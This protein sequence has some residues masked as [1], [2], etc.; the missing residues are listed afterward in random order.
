MINYKKYIFNFLAPLSS[1]SL[2]SVSFPRIPVL[3]SFA[4]WGC[5]KLNILSQISSNSLWYILLATSFLFLLVFE[6]K[7][8]DNPVI[9]RTYPII[10]RDALDEIENRAG[11]VN[12]SPEM[13]GK[14]ADWSALQS[15]IL[16]KTTIER[17]R[18]VIPWF[19]LEMDIPDKDGNIIYPRG[20][21]FNPLEFTPQLSTRL[22]IVDT[23]T[24]AWGLKEAGSNDMV[25]LAGGNA[26][27]ASR[28]NGATIFKLEASIR[29]RLELEYVPSVVWQEGAAMIV[30][31]RVIKEPSDD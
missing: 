11:S 1:P 30:S 31:E 14:E 2:V 5:R 17:E 25:L 21:T 23:D 26:L 24:L 16:P 15:P 10:E 6:A 7:A 27:E 9:G 29:E 8:I 4:G 13:F 20:Y 3:V 22:I 18:T 19:T 12:Y 28:S